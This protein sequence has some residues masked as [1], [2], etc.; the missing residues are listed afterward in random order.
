MNQKGHFEIEISIWM[1]AILL[2]VC[3]FFSIQRHFHKSHIELEKNYE[4]ELAKIR[5]TNSKG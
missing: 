4:R 2:I 3:A 5:G 1:T